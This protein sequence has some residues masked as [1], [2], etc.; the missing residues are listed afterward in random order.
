MKLAGRTALVTGATGGLGAAI[1]RGLHE[2]GATLVLSGRRTEVLEELARELGDA[3][4]VTADMAQRADVERLAR[5]CT[6][7]DVLVANAGLP[8]DGPVLEYTPEQLDRALDV[9]LRAP[10]QLARALAEPMAARGEG[11]LVFVSSLSG[12]VATA[13]SALY[14]ATKFG[15]RGF[16]S[17][18][19]QDLRGTGVGVSCVF[20][21]PIRGAGM[22][23]ETGV[24]M[25]LGAG[26]RSPADVGRAVVRAIERDVGEI[27]VASVPAKVW[28]MVGGVAPAT[29]ARI[30]HR[31]G[32]TTISAAISGSD[33][34]R[35]KR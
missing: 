6:G 25:P 27:D 28:T 8:A 13:N 24:K 14:S 12:K 9:N 23:A 26:T 16:S 34:H 11:H 19:R 20:P 10:V 35:A 7:V 21:G 33:A 1:A 31:F 22:F 18:L 15:L 17:G 30:N 2:A 5:E 4:A 29:M 32:G 3:R